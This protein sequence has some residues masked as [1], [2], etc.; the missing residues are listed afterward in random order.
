MKITINGGSGDIVEV[1]GYP[2]AGEFIT[3]RFRADLVAPDGGQMRVHCWFD[4]EGGCWQVGVG[5]TFEDHQLPPW[6]VTISQAPP[7][8]PDPEVPGYSAL[9]TID[10]PDGT[11]LTPADGLDD[12]DA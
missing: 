5:Q 10:A 4:D 1:S 2:G 11:T 3:D 8:N 7:A 9:L 12:N 6:P